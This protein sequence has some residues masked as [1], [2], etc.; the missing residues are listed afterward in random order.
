MTQ[1]IRS[2]VEGGH[3]PLYVD[4]RTGSVRSL[5]GTAATVA[6]TLIG[7]PRFMTCRGTR[8]LDCRAGG[9][10]YA[11]Q[12]D[13]LGSELTLVCL[14]DFRSSA[15]WASGRMITKR[16]AGGQNFEMY[17]ATARLLY[18]DSSSTNTATLTGWYGRSIGVSHVSGMV[19]KLYANG[20]DVTAAG[21][22]VRT[23]PQ[24][25]VAMTVGCFYAFAFGFQ[26]PMFAAIMV[27][28]ALSPVDMARLH[29]ELVA[30]PGIVARARKGFS[31]PYPSKT[32]AEVTAESILFD[33][34][35]EPITGTLPDVATGAYPATIVGRADVV[36]GGP[37]GSAVSLRTSNDYGDLPA[38]VNAQ[39]FTQS[40][41]IEAWV[42]PHQAPA[43]AA[44]VFGATSRN[45]VGQRGGS[46]LTSYQTA[47]VAQQTVDGTAGTIIPWKHQHFVWTLEINGANV[48]VNQYADGV[49]R[50]YATFATGFLTSVTDALINAYSAGSNGFW[51]D[52]SMVRYY[53]NRVLTPAEVR[54]NYLEGARKCLLDASVHSDGSCPVSLAALGVGCELANGWKV[55]SGTWKVVE[56]A[57]VL[58]GI[59]GVRSLQCV[60]AGTLS[61]PDTSAYGSWL[62]PIKRVAATGV[63][64]NFIADRVGTVLAPLGYAVGLNSGGQVILVRTTGGGSAVVTVS[65][66]AYT[67]TNVQ[68]WLWLTRRF[69]GTFTTWIRGG[70]YTDWTL[71]SV[72]GGSG[73]NPG[74]D[75]TY[76]TSKFILMQAGVSDSGLGV[77][78]YL[79]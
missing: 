73:A 4:F 55:E 18:Y 8:A 72:I 1:F 63:Y 14:A 36:K 12:A 70:A 41:S 43:G 22:L 71:V 56:D 67:T 76:T 48:T 53:K 46:M 44:V 47:A 30:A 59:P 28:T 33:I 57:P 24:F 69:D 42:K 50:G 11:H 54:A 26:D 5:S 27:N 68:Y 79:G 61:T 2:L 51:G 19:P 45:Y 32:P 9:V 78:H 40:Y 60:T 38:A 13:Q 37:F 39:I 3:V 6:P 52:Y 35:G 7:T 15:N 10:Q 65:P 58:P 21:A 29:R 20:V 23:I 62:I 16:D 66:N 25:N 49:N 77:V 17:C 74:T 34:K 75:A 31:I 64:V